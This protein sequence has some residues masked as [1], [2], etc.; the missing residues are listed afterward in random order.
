MIN[1]SPYLPS[2]EPSNT[3][4]VVLSDVDR[5]IG[6]ITHN[7]KPSFYLYIN[8]CN[9]LAPTVAFSMPLSLESGIP[10]W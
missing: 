4:I 6:S 1:V 7:G 10:I 2:T 9:L 8:L 5:N 3:K